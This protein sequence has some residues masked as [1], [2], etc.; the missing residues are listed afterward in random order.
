MSECFLGEIRIFAGNFAPVRWAF[1]DGQILQV[2]QND[3]L[4]SLLGTTYGGDGVTT[5]AL[6]D[7]R[8][9]IPVHA[10][11]GPGLSQRNLGERSGV[12][13]V[14]LTT[15]Q[16]SSHSHPLQVSTDVAD[17]DNPADHVLDQPS[18]SAYTESGPTVSMDSSTI[19]AVGGNQSHNNMMPYLCINFIIS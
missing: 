1:C 19:T 12:E 4:Y 8:G 7:M 2:S 9:R 6:P 15:A 14:T 10:G 5:F 16:L 11:R 13:I 18:G 17:S 3:A